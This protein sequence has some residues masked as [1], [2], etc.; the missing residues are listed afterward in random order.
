MVDYK[1][2]YYKYKAK[3]YNLLQQLQQSGGKVFQKKQLLYIV[4][5]ISQQ[6]LKK[7]TKELTDTIL[8]KN[9]KPYRAPHITLFHIMI[10]A[11]NDDN[12][13]FQDEK[14]YNKIAKIYEEAIA[15]KD[16]P[17]ILEAKPFPKDWT[18]PGYRPRYF[19]RNYKSLDPEKIQN[20][21]QQIFSLIETF[22]GKPK[23]KDYYDGWSKYYIYSYHGK[24][25]FAE[26][27]YYDKWKPHLDFMNDFDIEKHNPA[28][29]KKIEKYYGK[30]KV[31][32]LV[33]KIN[34][35]PLEIYN[36]INMATQMRKITY[37]ID[38]IL[39]KKFKI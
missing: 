5:T 15:D 30:G 17:L 21:R 10:N 22:L 16:D 28:L 2:K 26:S 23:I 20:F 34:H 6:K 35:L 13:I 11:E 3:Y 39:Q 14:F 19:L 27:S 32:L 12:K 9:V 4:A 31:D 24:E 8:G 37:A 7:I 36:E 18:L 38:H 1:L 29:Y 25:L 33:N